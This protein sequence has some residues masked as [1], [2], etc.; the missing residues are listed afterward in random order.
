VGHAPWAAGLGGTLAHFLQSFKSA[1]KAEIY[2]K[3]CLKMHI[4]NCKT[5]L[6]VGSFVPEPLLTTSSWR[7][8]P[9][10]RVVT[11]TYNYAF[12][13]FVSSA[14]Y[15]LLHTKKEEQNIYSKFSAFASCALSIYFSLKAQ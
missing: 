10:P 14:R 15:V 6:S 13:E 9:Q 5:H 11:S 7:L 3:V 1:V 2:T 8:C 4:L 12:V